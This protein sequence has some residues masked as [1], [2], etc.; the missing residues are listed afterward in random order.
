M[1]LASP[2]QTRFWKFVQ[3]TNACWNWTGASLEKG[4]G[5]IGIGKSIILAH[6]LSYLIHLGEIPVGMLVCHTCD[7]PRCVNPDHLFL[8]T[9]KDN[10]D[11][12]RRKNRIATGDRHG[13]RL[14]PERAACGNNNGTHT[15]PHRV[16]KGERLPQAK[17]NAR[18]ILNIRR[19][20]ARGQTYASIARYYSVSDVTIKRVVERKTWKHI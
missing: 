10:F 20:R 5:R 17:L 11:D 13:L 18:A 12:A 9:H 1:P 2:V 4:Y 15:C 14:H 16:A 3:K 8:G 19:L 7:N 6:R